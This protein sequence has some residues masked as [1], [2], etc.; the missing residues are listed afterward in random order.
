MNCTLRLELTP[1]QL[2]VA[3]RTLGVVRVAHNHFL[4]V[5]WA[6]R[7]LKHKSTLVD[8]FNSMPAA[9]AK[10]DCLSLVSGH[11]YREQASFVLGLM[12]QDR[13][14]KW[15]KRDS[16][17]QRQYFC[18]PGKL[19][20]ITEYGDIGV[21]TVGHFTIKGGFKL[22]KTLSEAVIHRLRIILGVDGEWYCVVYYTPID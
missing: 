17:R 19:A 21:D 4:S 15:F 13:D 8:L 11:I 5:I 3:R 16:E 12:A 9:R 6:N 18:V 10:F 7:R 22:R 1:E 2:K 14:V 20:S